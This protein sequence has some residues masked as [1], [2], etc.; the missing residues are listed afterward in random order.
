MRSR[1]RWSR[2]R[3]TPTRTWA[4][5]PLSTAP[6]LGFDHRG[7]GRSSCPAFAGRT[8]RVPDGPAPRNRRRPGPGP[9]ACP[10]RGQC[11]ARLPGPTVRP[12]GPDRR[13]SRPSGVPRI[14]TPAVCAAPSA[15]PATKRRWSGNAAPGRPSGPGCG[16]RTLPSR[17]AG[18]SSRTRRGSGSRGGGARRKP[19]RRPVTAD[20]GALL[21]HGPVR[22]AATACAIKATGSRVSDVRAGQRCVTRSAVSDSR[23]S[24]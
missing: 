10:R 5:A 4:D 8:A 20:R 3:T 17:R 11:A 6:A 7:R 22:C 21:V 12:P 9:G 19:Y 15:V 13:A 16:G 23:K 14:G 18:S 24:E 2:R 1:R